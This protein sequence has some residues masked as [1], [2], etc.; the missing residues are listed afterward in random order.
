MMTKIYNETPTRVMSN[1]LLK[2][3]TIPR[4]LYATIRLHVRQQVVFRFQIPS[5]LVLAHLVRL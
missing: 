2:D 1:V 5:W 4:R 3:Q